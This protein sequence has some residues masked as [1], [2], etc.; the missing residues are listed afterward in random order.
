MI[1]QG[2]VPLSGRLVQERQGRQVEMSFLSARLRLAGGIGSL[3]LAL[4]LDNAGRQLPFALPL[5][6]VAIDA[7]TLAVPPE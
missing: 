3:L 2:L 6:Y 7:A 4:F 5:G 1:I